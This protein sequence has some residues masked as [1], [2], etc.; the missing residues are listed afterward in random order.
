MAGSFWTVQHTFFFFFFLSMIRCPRG[1]SCLMSTSG[2]L[3]LI[4]RCLNGLSPGEK[5]SVKFLC[6]WIAQQVAVRAAGSSSLVRRSWLWSSLA[7]VRSSESSLTSRTFPAMS[8]RRRKGRDPAARV[9][10]GEPLLL[11]AQRHLLTL[12][13]ATNTHKKQNQDLPN[14]RTAMGHLYKMYSALVVFL[15]VQAP[16]APP[17]IG[18][19]ILDPLSEPMNT[20]AV[21]LQGQSTQ[22][23][24]LL[25]TNSLPGVDLACPTSLPPRHHPHTILGMA[26]VRNCPYQHLTTYILGL[27]VEREGRGKIEVSGRKPSCDIQPQAWRTAPV[28]F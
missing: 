3:T 21:F 14:Q 2:N 12:A 17:S 26:Q 6:L 15:A 20:L 28:L 16:Q 22:P 9:P 27:R 4:C 13:K 23:P 7:Q 8:G 19:G 5:I 18:F 24:V 10:Q 11:L 1:G 25:P